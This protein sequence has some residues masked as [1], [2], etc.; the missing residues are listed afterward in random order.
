MIVQSRSGG[1]GTLAR[2]GRMVLPSPIPGC[3]SSRGPKKDAKSAAS[4]PDT[5]P[6]CAVHHLSVLIT[7]L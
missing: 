3:T 2:P 5:C 6:K 4:M 7:A 1:T